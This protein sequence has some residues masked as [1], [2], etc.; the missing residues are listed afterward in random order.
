MGVVVVVCV[1]MGGGGASHV[2]TTIQENT[3]ANLPLFLQSR[4]VIT[5]TARIAS[6]TQPTTVNK[7]VTST[8]R[9]TRSTPMSFF[10]ADVL[11]LGAT[12]D[13]MVA[14]VTLCGGPV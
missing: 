11:L 2:H 7:A 4:H 12:M 3:E 13:R 10:G 8:H 5:N 14:M 6:R 1:C 9:K